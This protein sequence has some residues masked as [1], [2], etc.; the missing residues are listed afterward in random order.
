MEFPEEEEM[1]KWIENSFNKIIA[2]NFQVLGRNTDIQM[3]ET[4]KSPDTLNLKDSLW[5]TL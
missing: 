5:E 4:K 3:Q 1:G 2:K